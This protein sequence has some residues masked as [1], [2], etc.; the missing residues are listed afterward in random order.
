MK[1]IYMGK[2]SK[3]YETPGEA[4]ESE[5]YRIIYKNN[6]GVTFETPREARES[7]TEEAPLS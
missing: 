5:P 7:E 2:S 3:L 1:T 4:K 6:D